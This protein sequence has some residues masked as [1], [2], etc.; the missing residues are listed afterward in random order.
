MAY[1]VRKEELLAHWDAPLAEKLLSGILPCGELFPVS[2]TEI[3]RLLRTRGPDAVK[4]LL[5]PAV[6]EY[7]RIN[8]LYREDAH[9]RTTAG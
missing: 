2:S 1:A 7:I 3:R 4:D 9:E 8:N 5:H 6:L